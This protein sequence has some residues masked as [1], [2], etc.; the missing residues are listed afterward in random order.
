M[1]ITGDSNRKPMAV[2]LALPPSTT[3]AAG[4]A[5][6]RS[7]A[8][9][10]T[11]SSCATATIRT[12]CFRGKLKGSR[13]VAVTLLGASATRHL[14]A[15]PAIHPV[16]PRRR[17]A[18][19]ATSAPRRSS[20]RARS[21]C[22]SSSRRNVSAA[23]R[24][25]GNGDLMRAIFNVT[26]DRRSWRLEAARRLA[27]DVDPQRHAASASASSAPSRPSCAA[28]AS[29]RAWSKGIE[30]QAARRSAS[31]SSGRRSGRQDRWWPVS[32][33][34]GWVGR[35]ADELSSR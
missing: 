25:A 16:G 11:R 14:A 12:F 24:S 7:T 31:A 26:R 19:S 32:A 27:L 1:R 17:R 9:G 18:W 22:A 15:V 3:D 2:R 13:R 4:R 33:S 29:R 23:A 35:A 20:S 6:S 34:H 28:R 21:W 5:T 30:S 10:S 8:R